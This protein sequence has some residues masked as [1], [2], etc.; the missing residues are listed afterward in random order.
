MGYGGRRD[1]E[2]APGLPEHASKRSRKKRGG[3]SM[4]KKT[5]LALTHKRNAASQLAI[6][7]QTPFGRLWEDGASKPE[8]I[9]ERLEWLAAE[10]QIDS[11]Q[12][13]K[14]ISRTEL[15]QE[16]IDFC[17]K[18]DVSLDWLY[19]A[20]GWF[21][22]LYPDLML[23]PHCFVLRQALASAAQACARSRPGRNGPDRF[24]RHRRARH[25]R[26]RRL[27]QEAQSRRRQR[28]ALPTLRRSAGLRRQEPLRSATQD[29]MS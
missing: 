10:W 25:E 26:G 22:D 19:S 8:N 23:S 4:A 28:R 6:R 5:K 2:L 11:E 14:K 18:Y 21:A 29:S 12:L 1:R 16:V 13:P 9:R 24:P 20:S 27:Q 3:L 17:E 7:R 15:T